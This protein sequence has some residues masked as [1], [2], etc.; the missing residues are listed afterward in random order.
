LQHY[1][2]TN[3]TYYFRTYWIFCRNNLQ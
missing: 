2:S 1:I 3:F